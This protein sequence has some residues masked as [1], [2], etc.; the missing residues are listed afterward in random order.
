MQSSDPATHRRVFATQTNVGRLQSQVGRLSNELDAL[1]RRCTKSAA[2][3]PQGI[4]AAPAAHVAPASK[5]AA[6]AKSHGG[7]AG[8][9]APWYVLVDRVRVAGA[10]VVDFAP[11]MVSA[12]VSCACEDNDHSLTMINIVTR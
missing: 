8:E 4:Y 7:E 12:V 9:P 11:N 2:A 3:T 10:R 1:R 5:A 6:G